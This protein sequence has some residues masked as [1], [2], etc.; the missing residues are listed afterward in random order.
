MASREE[1]LTF[2]N[3]LHRV[4]ENLGFIGGV[5]GSPQRLLLRPL[6][7][8]KT[9]E[10]PYLAIDLAGKI[11]RPLPSTGISPRDGLK[12]RN[13]LLL[14]PMLLPNPCLH[15]L[16]TASPP[17]RALVRTGSGGRLSTG[18]ERRT[19]PLIYHKTRCQYVIGI[20]S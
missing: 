6:E 17:A 18:R 15:L 16:Q 2:A 10:D 5:C 11:R 7:Q 13:L 9:V 19:N 12:P 4:T 1:K 8:R 14:K 20:F 3:P